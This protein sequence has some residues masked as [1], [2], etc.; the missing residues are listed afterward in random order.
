MS[1]TNAVKA[2]VQSYLAG[3]SSVTYNGANLAV[4]GGITATGDI[5]A[6]ASDAR[7]K[8]NIV[9]IPQALDKVKSINGVTYNWNEIAAQFGVG[10]SSEHAGVLAQ[11]I[12]SVLPQVVKQAPF[13]TAADGSSK[14]GEHYLTVQY[15]KIIPLLIEAIKELAAE[16]EALKSRG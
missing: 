16:V 8:T 7:L 10:D 4:T 15:D 9:S 13:D 3:N 5:T 2:T 6:F 1:K 11:E 12:Q 14:S